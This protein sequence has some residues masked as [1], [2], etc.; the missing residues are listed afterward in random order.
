MEDVMHQMLPTDCPG[1]DLILKEIPKIVP[2]EGLPTAE[3]EAWLNP[4]TME[5]E[6]GVDGTPT[7][8]GWYRGTADVIGICNYDGEDMPCVL[9]FKTG[10][11]YHQAGPDAAQL[12]YFVLWLS[13]KTQATKIAS[14][15]FLTRD[16]TEPRLHIWTKPEIDEFAQRFAALAAKLDMIELD[17]AQPTLEKNKECFF[18]PCR[19]VCPL[20][21]S[22]PGASRPST[23]PK[24]FV[25]S[26][27]DPT[28]EDITAAL[29]VTKS[30]GET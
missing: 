20:Q 22:A 27:K 18:C 3:V 28:A 23:E 25:P 15:V 29:L 24:E 30:T 11:P 21:Q 14:I 6:L 1:F 9:D 26:A 10:S 13:I 19:S 4:L 16:A 12:A 5:A 17:L 8:P 7:P 2:I